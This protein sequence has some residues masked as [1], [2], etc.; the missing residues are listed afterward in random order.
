MGLGCCKE[1]MGGVAP[2]SEFKNQAPRVLRKVHG[3]LGSTLVSFT[4]KTNSCLLMNN[5][6]W[7]EK[8][9]AWELCIH[10]F[11]IRKRKLGY[12][13]RNRGSKQREREFWEDLLRKER[14][15]RGSKHG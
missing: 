3:A 2:V 9:V 4:N 14:K 6:A 11:S 1:K 8:L 7:L 15:R 5:L 12:S 13:M 10:K